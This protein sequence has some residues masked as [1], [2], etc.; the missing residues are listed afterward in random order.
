MGEPIDECAERM[1]RARPSALGWPIWLAKR[2]GAMN[3]QDE[4]ASVAQSGAIAA[5]GTAAT[6]ELGR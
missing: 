2:A 6:T 3:E 1:E 5:T 4:F